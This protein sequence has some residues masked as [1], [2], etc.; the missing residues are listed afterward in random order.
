MRRFVVLVCAFSLLASH[1]AVGQKKLIEFGWD[2]PSPAFVAANVAIMERQPFSGVVLQFAVGPRVFKVTGVDTL[3][4]NRDAALLANT[5]FHRFTDNFVLMGL[6]PDS[7]WDWF[8]DA[9]WSIS[10]SNVWRV[11]R[12]AK[13]AGL[14]GVALDYE[15][16]GRNPW[17]F[18]KLPHGNGRTFDDY[19][20]QVRA[21]GR[22]V[23]RALQAGYPDLTILT[24]FQM[25]Y[26]DR[27]AALAREDGRNQA[28]ANTDYGLLASFVAGM[29]EA[30]AGNSRIVDGNERAYWYADSLA[31]WK[32]RQA[33][34]EGA[35]TLIPAAVQPVYRAHV[36]VGQTVFVDYLLGMYQRAGDT[37]A[38]RVAPANRIRRLQ[39]NLYQALLSSDEYVWAYS[40]KVNWWKPDSSFP[41]GLSEAVGHAVQAANGGTPLGIS[42]EDLFR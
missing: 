16:Y 4:L 14:R 2:R 11:A 21:R 19:A 6:T 22:R 3:S 9:R 35:L 28:L 36:Q 41:A 13:A 31:F 34:K 32:G 26:L 1:A 40:Q 27:V 29:L 33:I 12:A 7:T 20:G 17:D 24:F 18:R 10:E 23:M 5:Q 38:A 8:D 39:Y 15:P 30:A 37:L 42:R 25:S